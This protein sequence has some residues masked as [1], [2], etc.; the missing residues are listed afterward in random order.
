MGLKGV[1]TRHEQASAME[2]HAYTRVTGRPG[3]CMTTAGP[4]ATN[5]VTGIANALVDCCPVITLG[6]ASPM[7][8]FG[9]GGWQEFDQLAV[10]KTVTK[11]ADRALE[12][13]R[14]PEL[15]STAFRQ[16]T[17]G[18]PG[19]NGTS[20]NKAGRRHWQVFSRAGTLSGLSPA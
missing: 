20:S 11:W 4:G 8:H 2:A 13:R 3:I 1:S 14:I 7:A 5:A 18:K 12:T 16:A 10:M 17:I 19:P 15:I 9:R 6:G